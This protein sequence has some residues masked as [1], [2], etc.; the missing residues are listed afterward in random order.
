M[1]NTILIS[2]IVPV[3]NCLP[4][5]NECLQSL[6]KQDRSSIEIIIVDDGSTDGSGVICDE[7]AVKY[8]G[9]TVIHQ[10]N[11][12]VSAARNKGLDKAIG[13]YIGF[14]DAD[15][16]VAPDYFDV[17]LRYINK[18]EADFYYFD[19][20]RDNDDIIP[21]RLT[22]N[23]ASGIIMELWETYQHI[24]CCRCLFKN[25][26]IKSNNIRFALERHYGEDQEFALKTILYCTKIIGVDTALY[27]Y[28][29]NQTSAVYKIT[30][31]LFQDIEAMRSV[32]DYALSKNDSREQLKN[33]YYNH[34]F[35]HS[36]YVSVYQLLRAKEHPARVLDYLNKNGYTAI[37]KK[38]RPSLPKYRRFQSCM[39]FSPFICLC[40]LSLRGCM[41]RFIY[42]MKGCC[43]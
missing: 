12:G 2:V 42:L 6:V 36:V 14:V 16:W 25:E 1:G 4:Y 37:I 5:L 3:Y 22:A 43:I 32:L 18:H 34:R 35:V 23:N 20:K 7:F 21:L 9:V 24:S 26:I 8:Q 39:S 10:S 28:R 30:Y 15:D 38:S 33:A 17:L 29:K 19:F 41:G 31:D 40:L 13:V 11:Q 27:F